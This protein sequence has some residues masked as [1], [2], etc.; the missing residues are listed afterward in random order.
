MRSLRGFLSCAV[1]LATLGGCRKASEEP[2]TRP[3]PGGEFAGGTDS[4]TAEAVARYVGSLEFDTS[5]AAGDAQYL[6]HRGRTGIGLGHYV[7]I[8]PE[9]GA[10]SLSRAS[11]AAGRVIARLTYSRGTDTARARLYY[12][13]D[14]SSGSWRNMLLSTDR[15]VVS[16]PFPMEIH[17]H[18]GGTGVRRVS[19]RARLIAN[20]GLE[21]PITVC[22]FCSEDIDWCGRD[23]E[24]FRYQGRLKDFLDQQLGALDAPPGGWRDPGMGPMRGTSPRM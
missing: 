23:E 17:A 7:T 1:L 21:M 8:A 12:F 9:K 24:L 2:A 6:V 14:S 22:I 10:T 16:G 18:P 5:V 11:L 20:V 13:V 3:T 19:P 4:M 15:A